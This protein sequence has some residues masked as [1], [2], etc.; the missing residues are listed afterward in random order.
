MRVPPLSERDPR[1]S[2]VAAVVR[3]GFPVVLHVI[4]QWDE[5]YNR[6]HHEVDFVTGTKGQPVEFLKLTYEEIQSAY[7]EAS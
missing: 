4:T 2:A 3:G 7:E 6:W 5:F 1:T